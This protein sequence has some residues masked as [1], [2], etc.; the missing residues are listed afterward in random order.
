VAALLATA[1]GACNVF[2]DQ[3]LEEDRRC[4]G[5]RLEVCRQNDGSGLKAY[6]S[7]EDCDRTPGY[8]C[9]QTTG[10]NS[11]SS[12]ACVSDVRCTT[13]ACDGQLA[14]LCH[15]SGYV[16]S[17]TDCAA[18]P[19]KLCAVAGAAAACA[20]AAAPCPA[21]GADSFC[22]ADGHRVWSGCGASYGYATVV[23]DCAD[24]DQVCASGNGVT[25]CVVAGRIACDVTLSRISCAPDGTAIYTC[26]RSGFVEDA[27]AC[28]TP[29]TTCKMTVSGS[30]SFTTCTN[31]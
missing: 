18:Q 20:Y 9:Q 3:C 6:T 13:S 1:G 4:V 28:R 19:G 15:P 17:T 7:S 26:G 21:S 8:T 12:A 5:N 25:E 22:D 29:G 31:P 10:V 14:V 27:S 16:Q 2:E 11:R 23:S 24:D 30:G